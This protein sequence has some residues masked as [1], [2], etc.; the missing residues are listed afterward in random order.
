LQE[1]Y[2]GEDREMDRETDREMDGQS[3]AAREYE[4]GEPAGTAGAGP[5]WAALDR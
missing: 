3:D 5:F 4:P 1:L 2:R